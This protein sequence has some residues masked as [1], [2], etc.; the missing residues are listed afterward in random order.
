MEKAVKLL[1][2]RHREKMAHIERK[3]LEDKQQLLRGNYNSV[4]RIAVSSQ[5]SSG[6]SADNFH[7]IFWYVGISRVEDELSGVQ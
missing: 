1:G 6:F 3:F 5:D 7:Q 4:E 2:D